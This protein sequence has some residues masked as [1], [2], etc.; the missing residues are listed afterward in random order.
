MSTR[1]GFLSFGHYAPVK[2][3][4]VRNS[5]EMLQQSVELAVNAEEVGIDGAYFRVH[6]FA[7]QAASPIPLLTA[8][9][10]RTSRIEMGTG[11][12]DMRYENPYRLAEEAAA[13][14]Q[15]SGGERLQLGISRGSPEPVKAGYQFFGTP[16][17][18][19]EASEIARDRGVELLRALDG[20]GIAEPDP[21][22]TSQRTRLPVYPQ[23]PSLRR[24]IWWGAGST[25]TAVWA[26]QHGFNLMSSTLLLENDG[27]DFGDLQASQIEAFRSAWREAGWDWEPRVSVSRSIIPIIDA[28]TEAYFGLRAEA[29]RHD[30]VGYLEGVVGRFGRS[31]IDSPDRLVTE[32]RRD[33]AVQTADTV[34]VTVPNMLGVDLNTRILKSISEDVRPGM[35]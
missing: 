31:Y 35:G 12:I 1:I 10:A 27:R 14:D 11:V 28:E 6:H 17:D 18:P 4:Q 21:D 16:A 20:E 24:R 13:T 25:S 33:A 26:A 9:G 15:L 22:Q 30:Q 5:T 8:V 29:D 3:S 34:L 23:D 32:L 19:A 7:R 2:G